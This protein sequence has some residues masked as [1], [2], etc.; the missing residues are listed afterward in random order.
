[1]E[2]GKN[3]NCFYKLISVYMISLLV[4]SSKQFV[5]VTNPYIDKKYASYALDIETDVHDQ[6]RVMIMK[7]R[8]E[9]EGARSAH[10]KD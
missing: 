4:V 5:S 6:E 10:A 7:R 8:R 2:T 1:M 3:L 9:R